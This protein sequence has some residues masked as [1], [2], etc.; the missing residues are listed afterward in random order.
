PADEPVSEPP[1]TQSPP[2]QQVASNPTPADKPVSEPPVTVSTPPTERPVAADPQPV[3]DP[4]TEVALPETSNH[5]ETQQAEAT[6]ENEAAEAIPENYFVL[7]PA[8]EVVIS[9][10]SRTLPPLGARAVFIVGLVFL[11]VGIALIVYM[12]LLWSSIG[13]VTRTGAP[14]PQGAIPVASA[15]TAGTF[16]YNVFVLGLFLSGLQVTMKRRGL[17]KRGKLVW[18]EVVSAAGKRTRS[19]ALN[20]TVEYQFQRPD[21]RRK[22]IIEDRVSEHRDSGA[23][24]V[25]PAPGTPIAVMYLHPRN[26]EVL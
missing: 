26:Y 18:G 4:V 7:N 25:L 21:R 15:W 16:L 12:A 17:E 11:A 8:N 22:R 5:R 6:S 9:G 3:A 13:S 24:V 23:D 2:P 20:I 1:V 10:D 14:A 19:G